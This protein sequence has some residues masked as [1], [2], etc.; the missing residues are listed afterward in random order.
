VQREEDEH[1]IDSDFRRGAG[2]LELL[3]AE[4]VKTV[5]MPL[6]GADFL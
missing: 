6:A 4:K 5:P 1:H 3:G 2:T